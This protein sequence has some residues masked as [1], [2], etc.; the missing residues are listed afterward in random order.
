MARPIDHE[1]RESVRAAILDAARAMV[2]SEGH[3]RF[4]LR[5]V[6]REAGIAPA[7]VYG[8]FASKDDLLAALAERAAERLRR[9]LEKAYDLRP[10]AKAYVRF[11]RTEPEDFLLLFS[12]RTSERRSLDEVD[13]RSPYDIVRDAAARELPGAD[14]DH[15]AYAIW[16]LVHGAVML[17]LTH[18]AGFRADFAAADDAA[19]EALIRGF[20]R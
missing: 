6:A 10:I 4:S 9:R 20:G 16:C 14:P 1:H 5:T 2:V 13:G 19:V 3:E 7:T 11:A 17:R 12:R 18:L 15:V 8:H